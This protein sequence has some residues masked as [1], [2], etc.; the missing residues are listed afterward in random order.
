ML[1]TIALSL[2]ALLAP[3]LAAC[4]ASTA[5]SP[6][7]EQPAAN[8]LRVEPETLDMG[9]LVPEVPVVKR[10][11]LTNTGT[12]PL[13]VTNAVA[14]CSCTTPTWPSEPIAPGATVET[15]ITMKA[16][17]K[18]G[19]TLT[20][21]VTFTVDG[22][23]LAFLN[24]VGKV[25]LFIELSS[26]MLR[27]PADDVVAPAPETVTMR[28]A[29]GTPFKVVGFD[30]AIATA[31]NGDSAL[32]HTATIDWLKWREL[33]KPTKLT[34]ITDHPKTPQLQVSIRRTV[35]QNAGAQPAGGP[36]TTAAANAA[37]KAPVIPPLTTALG[38]K[39]RTYK[40]VMP[41]VYPGADVLFPPLGDFVRG[42]ALRAFPKD[43]VVVFEFFSTTCGHCKEAGPALEALSR[44]YGAKGWRFISVTSEDATKVKAYFDDPV[45]AE[46]YPHAIALDPGSKAQK[47]LQDPTFEVKNPRLFAVRNGVVLWYGHPDAA[48]EPFAKI[49]AGTWDPSAIR[50]EFITNALTARARSQTNN[51]VTQCE[52]DGKWQ[53]LLDLFES[54]AVGIP[55][56]ASTFEL[57]RFGTMIG[58]ADMS[59]AGYAYGKQLAVHYA[60]DIASLRTLAR[61]TLNSPRVKVRDLEFAFALARAA[62][63]LGNGQDARAAEILALAYFSRGDRDNAILHQERAI[64]LQTDAKLKAQWEAQLNKYRTAE[65]GPVPY[66]P[67]PGTAPAGTPASTPATPPQ[68]GEGDGN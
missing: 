21:R 46:M 33:K 65:P 39:P 4:D 6:R 43:T 32:N 52:K 61:T 1:R 27:A 62:D 8:A 67:K 45:N 55:D 68:G 53:E 25:G 50:A 24:V 2:L 19:V 51:L 41:G 7:A 26:D 13:T 66:T 47:A 28:G 35:S 30:Q 40:L 57:Q 60:K 11:K 17:P 14:D 31:D 48:A 58:P 9:D 20:K 63:Q 42:E 16:G 15:D 10:V 54:I 44:E 29:D 23:E 5:A 49:A 12:K 59:E 56:R 18:Q 36:P 37:P 64:G 22:G 38:K 34:I 3:A